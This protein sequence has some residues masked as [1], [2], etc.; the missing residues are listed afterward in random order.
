MSRIHET[1]IQ[2]PAISLCLIVRGHEG[3]LLELRAS[4]YRKSLELVQG[5]C[6]IAGDMRHLTE[7]NGLVLIDALDDAVEGRRGQLRNRSIAC[8]RAPIILT[9]D[10]SVFLGP[11]D[12][13]RRLIEWA[14]PIKP[15]VPYVF[16]F[17][18][19]QPNG[20]RCPDWVRIDQHMTYGSSAFGLWRTA[21]KNIYG[22]RLLWYESCC[23]GCLPRL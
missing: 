21:S 23:V 16:V 4:Y 5:E 11:P 7:A 8:S 13:T 18:I 10:T 15:E 1:H 20:E 22:C 19:L 12:W 2:G 3:R 6:V 17:P 14:S 9:S